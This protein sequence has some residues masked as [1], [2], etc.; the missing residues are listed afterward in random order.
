MQADWNRHAE[1]ARRTFWERLRRTLVGDRKVS[2]WLLIAPVAGAAGTLIAAWV[3]MP[4]VPFWAK[5]PVALLMAAY[6]LIQGAMYLA[7]DNPPDGGDGP[8][9]G[10]PVRPEPDPPVRQLPVRRRLKDRLPTR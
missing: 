5:A 6:M 7:R 10:A 4:D 8:D 3:I 1:P 2:P 9:G